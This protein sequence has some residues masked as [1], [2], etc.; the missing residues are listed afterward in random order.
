[1]REALHSPSEQVMLEANIRAAEDD[2]QHGPVFSVPPENTDSVRQAQHLGA[3][4][5]QQD[6]TSNQGAHMHH[7]AH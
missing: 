6:F 4:A 1:M 7:T 2:V 5:L 3:D